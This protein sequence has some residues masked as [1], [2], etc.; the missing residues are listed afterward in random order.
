M[1][2]TDWLS[3]DGTPH[4]RWCLRHFHPGQ[5][6]HTSPIT[7]LDQIKSTQLKLLWNKTA[8][9]SCNPC[10]VWLV[11]TRL[12]PVLHC[13]ASPLPRLLWPGQ[14]Q[15]TAHW[16]NPMMKLFKILFNYLSRKYPCYIR[17]ML[18]EILRPHQD[19]WDDQADWPNS[20]WCN[21]SLRTHKPDLR[22]LIFNPKYV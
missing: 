2:P 9:L 7:T 13:Q 5:E 12:C 16:E 3:N 15:H 22:K 17:L 11:V 6:D 21:T 19:A 14:D 18:S 4:G 1:I 8:K 10:L 20:V